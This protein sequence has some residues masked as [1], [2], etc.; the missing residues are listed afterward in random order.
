MMTKVSK[1]LCQY[2]VWRNSQWNKISLSFQISAQFP[3]LPP[4]L[5]IERNQSLTLM[6]THFSIDTPLPL[7]P[8]Q[9]EVGAMHCRPAKPL[10]KDLESWLAGSGSAGVIYFSLGSVARS[11]TMPPEYR[12]AFL[13]AFR[14]LPQRVLWEI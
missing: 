8:S 13:E 1:T 6:N 10:P 11:E 12:Q 2:L 7:L 9:V 5:E 14:R 3:D 4:L